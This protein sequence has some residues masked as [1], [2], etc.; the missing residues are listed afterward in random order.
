VLNTAE[1]VP[2]KTQHTAPAQLPL[3]VYVGFMSLF[4]LCVYFA[5]QWR[6]A[7]H[8]LNYAANMRETQRAEKIQKETAAWQALKQCLHADDLSA[9]RNSLLVW[10]RIFTH[11]DGIQNLEQMAQIFNDNL[12]SP[13]LTALSAALYSN[14]ASALQHTELLAVLANLRRQKQPKNTLE[15]GLPPLYAQQ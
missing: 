5:W 7:L 6:R 13:Q 9:L 15:A 10:A 11:N 14:Q 4:L 12:L 3:W 2:H 1:T 8:K